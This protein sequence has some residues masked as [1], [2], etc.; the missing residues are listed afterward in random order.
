MAV[1]VP[2]VNTALSVSGW[3]K[4]ITDQCNATAADV[5]KLKPGALTQITGLQ[6]GYTNDA[7]TNGVM[8]GKISDGWVYLGGA[9]NT[10]TPQ[11]LAFTVPA[12]F[13]PKY[14]QRATMSAY[15]SGG[16]PMKAR[17]DFYTDG[18]FIPWFEAGTILVSFSL[19]Y[20]I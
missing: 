19:I 3:G 6:N 13:T 7:F 15:A 17:G 16:A 11:V 4:P 8:Y 20:P 5:A 10:G 1:T 9:L 18:R 14:G 2:V 12:G